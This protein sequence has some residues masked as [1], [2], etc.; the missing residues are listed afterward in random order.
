ESQ[1]TPRQESAPQEDPQSARADGRAEVTIGRRL[2]IEKESEY[3]LNDESMRL[4]DV[5]DLLMDTGLGVGA[6]SVME[7]GRIDAVLSANPE[8]RRSIFEE[9]AGI[10]RYKLQK[11]ETLR[12]LERTEQ[13]LARVHDLIEERTKRIRG[14]KIQA[15]KARR[16]QEV[17]TRLWDLK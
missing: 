13:N 11:R 1:P 17:S 2:T 14:L 5:R 7:Q 12:K 6:Y 4:K 3:L 16:W 15:G 8:E 10:S 9:A